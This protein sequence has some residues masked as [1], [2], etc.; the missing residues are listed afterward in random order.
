M[1]Y[2]I[3]FDSKFTRREKNEMSN[4]WKYIKNQ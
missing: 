4:L 1:Y 2:A 3:I